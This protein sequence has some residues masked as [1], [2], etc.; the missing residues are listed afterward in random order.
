MK[1][2]KQGIEDKENKTDDIRKLEKLGENH[3]KL[4]V[5]N[6]GMRICNAK[7]FDRKELRDIY[8]DAATEIGNLKNMMKEEKR[9]AKI[10]TD[11]PK[12]EQDKIEEFMT[13]MNQV[14]Q[15]N[16]ALKA[17]IAIPNIEKQLKFL[18]SGQREIEVAIPEVLRNK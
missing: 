13:I 3:F 1:T 14:K 6:E 16:D 15:F 9:K 8:G 5:V 7:E 17:N 12:E 10:L 18:E 2:I 11:L 4:T